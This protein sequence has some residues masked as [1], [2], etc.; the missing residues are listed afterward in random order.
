MYRPV[1]FNSFGGGLNLKDQ[2]DV[3]R[4]DQ[5]IDLLNVDFGVRGSISQRNGYTKWTDAAASA[6]Y[7]S[8]APFYTTAG[9]A[10]V[11]AGYGGNLDALD[12]S[13]AVVAT[14][15]APTV[16]PH[17]FTR[18][19]GPASELLFC[20]NGTDQVR[21][22]NGS[23]F[24]VPVWTVTAP[25]GKFVAVT[26]WDNRLLSAA[27]VGTTAASNPSSLI[28]SDPGDPLA[29]RTTAPDLN[30]EQF[31]PG[32]GESITGMIAWRE[33][34]FVFKKT[35]FFVIYGT[36]VGQDGYPK[37]EYRRVAAGVGLAAPQAVCASRD[38]VYFLDASGVYRTRGQEPELV[39]D[40]VEPIFQGEASE[41]YLG[42]T[43]ADGVVS[44]CA[45]VAHDDKVY[46]AFSTGA[47]NDRMLVYDTADKWWT[48]YDIPARCLTTFGSGTEHP[49]IL[50]GYATGTNDIGSFNTHSDS[51]TS[52]AGEAITSRWRSGWFDYDDPGVKTIRESKLWAKG[53]FRVGISKD[54]SYA[55][56]RQEAVD[57]GGASDLWGDGLGADDWGDGTDPTD[58]WGPSSVIE[59]YLSRIGI[60]GTVF[61]VSFS[62]DVL[63]QTFR[64]HR[65]ANYLREAKIKS[66]T[67]V[68][69]L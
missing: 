39:S 66:T 19:G 4:S 38:G 69:S 48:L 41:F 31:T 17:F 25:T 51:D 62:N 63:D 13:G 55:V 30:Y 34:V 22:W 1:S 61:S 59:P 24:S 8:I 18:F 15:T 28:F 6:D 16:G 56:N 40:A 26:G 2:V 5:A 65:L 27:H 29:F 43:L 35:S 12:S 20:A 10:Q 57:L 21:Q 60:R 11:V 64:V 36:S 53:Q 47:T 49:Q 50:F 33:F 68:D 14:S 7:D 9:V 67:K 44:S 42:G 23:A 58:L 37:L 52:D 54:F 46:L 32:D 45:M 3:V